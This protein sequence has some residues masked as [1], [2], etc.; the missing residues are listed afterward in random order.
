[1]DFLPAYEF[2]HPIDKRMVTTDN[3]EKLHLGKALKETG[4]QVDENELD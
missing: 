4:I 1:M 3:I 2:P